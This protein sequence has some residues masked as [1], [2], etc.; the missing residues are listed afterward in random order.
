MAHYGEDLSE[1]EREFF[2]PGSGTEHLVSSFYLA[3]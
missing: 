1:E 2:A 3:F